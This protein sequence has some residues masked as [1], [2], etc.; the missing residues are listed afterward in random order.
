MKELHP[1]EDVPLPEVPT[2]MS[3]VPIGIKTSG[4]AKKTCSGAWGY[5]HVGS[6]DRPTDLLKILFES[7]LLDFDMNRQ[8][9]GQL[10]K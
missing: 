1:R 10:G 7:G 3:E 5:P 2:H 6:S 4:K 8:T 9:R